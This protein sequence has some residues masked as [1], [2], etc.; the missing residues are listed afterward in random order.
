MEKAADDSEGGGYGDVSLELLSWAL[1]PLG[2]G[3][4]SWLTSAFYSSSDTGRA[5]PTRFASL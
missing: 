2:Y 5:P 1:R 3:K 4:Q